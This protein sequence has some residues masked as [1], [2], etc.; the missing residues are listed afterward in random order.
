MTAALA[1]TVAVTAPLD[2]ARLLS[3]NLVDGVT[4]GNLP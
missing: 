1:D 3:E 2:P 4:D